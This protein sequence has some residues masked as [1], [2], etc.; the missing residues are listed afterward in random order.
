MAGIIGYGVYIPRYRIKQSDIAV[1]WGGFALGEKAVCGWDEDIITMAA[2][3]SSNSI[4]HAG[5]DPVQIGA[6]YL[7]TASSP[8]IEQY[9]AP[10]LAETLE[11][12]PQTTV[13]DFCGS[14]N[15]VSAALLACLDAIEAKRI[16]LGLVIGTE[17]RVVGPGTEGEQ[18]LGASAVAMVVGNGSTV[19]DFNGIGTYSTLF[20]DRWQAV[21]DGWVSNYFDYRFARE[22]GYQKHIAEACRGA[23]EKAG[24]Q[25]SDYA[26]VVLQQPDGRTPA[27]A[28]KEL[29]TKPDQLLPDMSAGLGDLGGCSA[30]VGL[31]GVLDAAKPGDKILVASYGSGSSNAFSMTVGSLID[32][33]RDKTAPLLKYLNR[34]EYVDYPTYLRLSGN[35]ARAPY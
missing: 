13:M 3:A 1:P 8:Y 19:A 17:N 27:L 16:N 33:K 24:T 2:E 23:M 32:Q 14:I 20:Y 35:L 29:G 34:K 22:F 25:S 31:A 10:I 26:R 28:G 6:V 18:N 21:K 5:V 11:L 9:V 30:F 7:G 15:A 4:K 12:R